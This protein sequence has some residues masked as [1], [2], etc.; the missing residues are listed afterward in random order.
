[1]APALT[2]LFSCNS[3]CRCAR[4][5]S[6]FLLAS[7]ALFS[8]TE[9]NISAVYRNPCLVYSLSIPCCCD[10]DPQSSSH[11][12]L[13]SSISVGLAFTSETVTGGASF[14]IDALDADNFEPFFAGFYNRMIK[15]RSWEREKNTYNDPDIND[16][17]HLKWVFIIYRYVDA[18]GLLQIS[19]QIV[20]TDPGNG[21]GFLFFCQAISPRRLA[22]CNHKSGDVDSNPG[23]TT[24]QHIQL[25]QDQLT[26][27][28]L[29]T[30]PVEV[31][32]A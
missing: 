25:H 5:S 9:N 18:V 3:F 6:R 23:P 4:F 15:P 1:M 12:S 16:I 27:T 32:G 28:D 13:L 17:C 26:V 8:T 7:S 29:W 2:A 14:C 24:N 19:A 30:S 22:G 31:V 11:P 21:S 10:C 20:S